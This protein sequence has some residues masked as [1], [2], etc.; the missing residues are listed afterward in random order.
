MRGFRDVFRIRFFRRRFARAV[1]ADALRDV[2]RHVCRCRFRSR[3]PGDI[4]QVRFSETFP[5]RRFRRCG[6]DCLTCEIPLL[7]PAIR[8]FSRVPSPDVFGPGSFPGH[9]SRD[10]FRTRIQ[11]QLQRRSPGTFSGDVFLARFRGRIGT[12]CFRVRFQGRLTES[13]FVRGFRDV[14]R[15]RFPGDVLPEPFLRTRFA[16]F[17]DTSAGAFSRAA[18]PETFPRYVFRR[19]FLGDVFAAVA[20]I[21]RRVKYPS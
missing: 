21:A 6:G 17:P 9:V 3:F 19:R 14:F 13:C 12:R 8:M 18:S 5:R 7:A 15:T 4:S 11:M 2:S 10:I 16:T 1:F 20:G